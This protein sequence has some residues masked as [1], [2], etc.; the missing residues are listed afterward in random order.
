MVYSSNWH[1]DSVG[2]FGPPELI[3]LSL[4]IF[5]QPKIQIYIL[6]YV[7]DI[8]IVSSFSSATSDFFI[9]FN[10]SLQSKILVH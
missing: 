9:I 5:S 7:Y 4:S 6:I 8:I 1:I 10:M 3:S 2:G